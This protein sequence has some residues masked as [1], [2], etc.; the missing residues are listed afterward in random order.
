M[1]GISE[2]IKTKVGITLG[3]A[4]SQMIFKCDL[5]NMLVKDC[6]ID[7]EH[8]QEVDMLGPNPSRLLGLGILGC[9][10]ASFIFCLKKRNFSVDD[11]NAEAEVIISRNEKGFLRIKKIDVNIQPKITDPAT[12][13]RA[14]QCLKAAKDGV[15]FFE[16]YCIV[17][18]SVRS[19]IEVNVN[20]DL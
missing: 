4:E 9:L 14:K 16:Q 7:E 8:H 2:E 17:T 3:E 5:G 15:S 19:G 10:S 20:L 12:L 18:Q 1:V 6:Y 11:F 13:K